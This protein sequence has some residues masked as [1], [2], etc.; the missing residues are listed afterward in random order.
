MVCDIL[1]SSILYETAGKKQAQ[2]LLKYSSL[3]YYFLKYPTLMFAVL[4]IS[5][6][7]GRLLIINGSS[8]FPG[9]SCEF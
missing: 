2:R 4:L 1:K 8:Y 5:T 6:D 7:Y 9:K 3:K